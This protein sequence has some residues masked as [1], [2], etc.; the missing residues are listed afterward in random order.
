M[1]LRWDDLTS[2]V[3]YAAQ[4]E[5]SFCLFNFY[6]QL[7]ALGGAFAKLDTQGPLDPLLVGLMLHFSYA[8]KTPPWWAASNAVAIEI[9]P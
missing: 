4:S 5:K 6:A 8:V 2:I 7:D 3:A 1:P 9:V